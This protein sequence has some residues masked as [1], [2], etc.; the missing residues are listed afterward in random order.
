MSAY[1]DASAILPTLVE[2]PGS[3]AIDNFIGSA[4][5]AL[6]IGEFAA[7]EVASALSRLVRT[8]VL[9][10]DDA[11][12]RLSDFDAWRA[13]ATEDVDLQASDVRLANI[14][15]RRFELMLRTPDAL[16]AAICRRGDHLL[17]T[18]DRR[19][20]AAAEELGV[21]VRLLNYGLASRKPS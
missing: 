16:H 12:A 8:G 7:A 3:R 13:V 9:E 6:M 15:V 18:M 11:M 14:F 10:R 19:L 4:G 17:V 21:R 2:E 20:A 1:L 5:E